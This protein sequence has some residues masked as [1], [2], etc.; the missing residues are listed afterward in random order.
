MDFAPLFMDTAHLK[1]PGH[2]VLAQAIAGKIAPLIKIAGAMTSSRAA[3]SV[4]IDMAHQ[5]KILGM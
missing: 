1:A 5:T 2:E 3:F 4:A